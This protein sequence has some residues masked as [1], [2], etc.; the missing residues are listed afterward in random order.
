MTVPAEIEVLPAKT[1]P[2]P[3]GIEV[4][5]AKISPLSAGIEV[6]PAKT[7]LLPAEIGVLSAK[8]GPLPTK[9]GTLPVTF[10]LLPVI[11]SCSLKNPAN[12]GCHPQSRHANPDDSLAKS[13]PVCGLYA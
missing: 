3:A 9:V 1:G 13:P 2:L 4:L 10:V 8:T 11:S 6:Q 12:N 5:P 7:G